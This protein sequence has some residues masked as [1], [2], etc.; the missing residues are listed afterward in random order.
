MPTQRI[1]KRISEPY[2][3]VAPNGAPTTMTIGEDGT[4]NAVFT[5]NGVLNVAG[6]TVSSQDSTISNNFLTLNVGEVGPGVTLLQSG[7]TVDRGFDLPLNPTVELPRPSIFWNE[8]TQEWQVQDAAGVVTSIGAFRVVTDPAPT[9]GGTL[10]PASFGI[11]AQPGGTVKI[12]PAIQLDISPPPTPV[13]NSSLLHAGL[14][15]HGET[16]L[17]TTTA[18]MQN[19]ELI[20][21]RKA[22]IYSL[23]F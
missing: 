17:Y 10:D 11:T 2:L 20:T 1:V 16:G 13:V 22:F 7:L 5:V 23:L 9:L 6:T 19:Q 12:N 15:G 8:P 3:I 21:A 4:T 18:A 14:P